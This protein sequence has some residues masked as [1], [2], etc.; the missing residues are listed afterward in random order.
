MNKVISYLFIPALMIASAFSCTNMREVDVEVGSAVTTISAYMVDDA[1]TKTGYVIDEQNNVARFNWLEGDQIDVAVKNGDAYTP[2]RFIAKEAGPV[3]GFREAAGD[4]EVTLESLRQANPTAILGDISYYPSRGN[5][6]A[7]NDGTWMEWEITSAGDAIITIPPVLCANTENPLATVPLLGVKMDENEYGFKPVTSVLAIPVKNITPDMDFISIEHETAALSGSFNESTG[8]TQEGVLS[9]A[10]HSL[11]LTYSNLDGDFTFFFPIAAGDIPAGLTIRCGK[12]SDPDAQ[13][14]LTT[15]NAVHFNPG[16]IGRCGEITFQ[17]VDQQWAD[18]ATGTFKDDFIWGQLGWGANAVPVTIQ[19]SGRHPEKF[20]IANPYSTACTT[21]GYTPYTDGIVADEYFVYRIGEDEEVSFTNMRLGVEDKTSGGKPLMASYRSSNAAYSRVV[22]RLANGTIV[23]LQ[24]A[25]FYSDPD[26]AG[27]YY[28]KDN[29]DG[30]PKIHLTIDDNSPEEWIAIGTCRFIDNFIWPYEGLTEYVEREIQQFSHDADRFRIAKPYP[31]EDADQWF[32]FNVSNPAAVTS[33]NYYT[34]TTV[35]DETK[36]D[37]TWKAV[38]WNGAYGYDYSNVISTQPNG[39]PLEV[40]IGPCYRD[41]EGIFTSQ[42][43]YDYEVGK[44][45]D[46]KV[47][48][49]I[50]PQPEETWTSLGKGRYTDEWMWKANGFAPY[51]VEVEIWRSDSNANRY[52]MENPYTAANTAFKRASSGTADEYMY[53]QVNESNGQVTFGAVVTGMSR[54]SVA[55]EQTKNFGIADAP[56]WE[57]IKS[58]G[59]A[60]SAGDSKVIAGTNANPEKIQ[61]YSSYYDSANVSY[62]Y[63][64]STGH[65]YVWF[66]GAYNS[67]ETWTT[68]CVGTY[69]DNFYDTTLNGNSTLGTVAVDIQQSSVNPSRFR[70]ANPYKQLSDFE[71]LKKGTADDYLYFQCANGLVYFETIHTGVQMN[72][73]SR[74]LAISHP[75]DAN[76]NGYYGVSSYFAGS[77]VLSTTT[78]GSP[79]QIQLGAY[80]YDALTP[81]TNY[82]YTRGGNAWTSNERIIITFDMSDAAVV[83]HYCTPI[84]RDFHNP[85]AL[86]NLPNGT[87]EKLVF[88]V[89]GIDPGLITGL[90]LYQG[91]WMDADYVAPD[92]NGIVTMNSFTNATVYGSIDLNLWY[93]GS[94][95]GNAI[96]IELQEA[97][98][99]GVSLPIRQDGLKN[100][101]GVRVNHGGDEVQVRGDTTEVVSSF[102]IPALVTSN[103]GTLIAAYD[104]RYDNSADL[105]GDID[106]G[107]KRSTDGGKTWSDLHLAMDMGITGYEDEIAAGTMTRKQAQLNNGIGDPC[108]LVDENTGRIFCFALWAHGHYYDGDRRVLA[109]SDKGYDVSKCGQF[110]MVWSDDDGLTWSEPENITRQIKKNDWR[111]TFQGPGRGITMK[112][113][114]LVVPIQHAEGEEKIMHGLY[115]LN[116]GIAYS[117]DHG[118]T[119]HAHN[120][121]WPVTGESAV[122]EIEPGTLMLSMREETGFGFRRVC[123]TSDL[124]RTWTEHSSSGKLV[125][126]TCEASLIHV[127]ANKNSL[128]KDLLLFSNPAHPSGRCRMTIKASLD[129]GVTWPYQLLLDAGGSLGY[130][131]L[132]MID[133]DTVG[134]L[135]ECS[136]GNIV[137]QAVPLADIV[138]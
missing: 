120:Y 82:C 17:A 92:A 81:T 60:I 55:A 62:F 68:L 23:E 47:I 25:A 114:T 130:S 124:G 11:K 34:G 137:F 48:H 91:G 96:A 121:A 125:D 4:G 107:L 105:Q 14:A 45:H 26:N 90:R 56:T 39:L 104:V 27:Y 69:K 138:K 51:D 110:M 7:Q 74:E 18:F 52:R 127:D 134:I 64:N 67:G 50:F 54:Q 103:N 66:P 135:Y 93:T 38:I 31:A 43:N 59:A 111:A 41:S 2:V 117:Y 9:G 65:K 3:S 86:L 116:G 12:S 32:E 5:V 118:I 109:W 21:F 58:S 131:C 85:V 78:N 46:A 63:T 61:L 136:R 83:E 57:R 77:S 98:V 73:S 16:F 113:G 70:I 79:Q 53:L 1:A 15:T 42:Y 13:M 101:P 49:I 30:T 80:W 76:V 75:V 94:I 102:R 29:F 24:F 89:S 33:V 35:S 119:W 36:Q 20:R 37:V 129:K 88:R 128:G 44:D 97:V 100:Y 115:P 8:V 108:L 132:S 126:P 84:I 71:T 99:D 133:E 87:L 40:Q 106:V 95:I 22:R 28:T 72:D 6:A 19:R 10:G 122:V 112:D 123:T